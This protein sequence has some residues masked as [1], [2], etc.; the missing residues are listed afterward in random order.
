MGKSLAIVGPDSYEVSPHSQPWV[1]WLSW[2]NKPGEHQCGGTL[3]SNRHVLTAEHCIGPD[4]W[5]GNY[6]V[7]GDH[8]LT[9]NDGERFIKVRRGL[10]PKAG[11]KMISLYNI[12]FK[13]L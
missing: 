3:I 12:L 1:V 11:T 2:E 6:V 5:A 13:Y 4:K 9:T 8:D 10:L 7:V